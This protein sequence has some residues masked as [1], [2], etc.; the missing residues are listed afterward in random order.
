[1]KK[2]KELREML[3]E[4]IEGLDYAVEDEIASYAKEKVCLLQEILEISDEDL[5]SLL[6]SVNP[7]WEIRKDFRG[8]LLW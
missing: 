2:E 8:R 7:N 6:L 3:I 4:A 5:V 1:M